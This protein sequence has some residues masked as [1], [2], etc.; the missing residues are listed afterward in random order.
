[1][2]ERPTLNWFFGSDE[3]DELMPPPEPMNGDHGHLYDSMNFLAR[4]Q[5]R[6]FTRLARIELAVGLGVVL[7]MSVLIAVL[8][9]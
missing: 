4:G 5:R 2:E 6:I 1:M 7:A 8:T 9:P 3:D